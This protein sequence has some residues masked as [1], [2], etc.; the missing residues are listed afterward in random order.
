MVFLDGADQSVQ[1]LADGDTFAFAPTELIER[2]RLNAPGDHQVRAGFV[3]R[4]ECDTQELHELG[5]GAPGAFGNV[6]RYGIRRPK[7]LI[8]QPWYSLHVEVSRRGVD[9]VD[10]LQGRVE[11]FQIPEIGH[12][13]H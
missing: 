2:E 6:G 12:A 11:D 4:P 9:G 3:C 8:A 10:Q 13:A 1:H 5:P 7:Q